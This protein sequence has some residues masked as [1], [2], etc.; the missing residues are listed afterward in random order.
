MGVGG[1]CITVQ[2]IKT[3][4]PYL[5]FSDILQGD[6]EGIKQFF[7]AWK[8]WKST[9]CFLAFLM[10]LRAGPQSFSVGFGWLGSYHLKALCLVRLSFFL[11]F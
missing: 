5:V 2:Q 6:R 9:F 8:E 4:V 11:V 7:I 10:W 3:L 1:L